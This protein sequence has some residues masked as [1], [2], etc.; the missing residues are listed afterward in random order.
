MCRNCSGRD[1]FDQEVAKPRDERHPAM[2][3][4]VKGMTFHNAQPKLAD[5]SYGAFPTG[6]LLAYLTLAYTTCTSSTT[7]E[8]DL[9]HGS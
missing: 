8:E 2:Q 9:T 6:P 5:G 4:R 1:W 7:T 3:W